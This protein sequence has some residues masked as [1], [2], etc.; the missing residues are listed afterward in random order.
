MSFSLT[1]FGLKEMLRCGL[2]LRKS[3]G[4]AGTLEEVARTVVRYFHDECR[5]AEGSRECLLARFYKTH[6]YGGLPPDLQAFA[7]GVLAPDPPSNDMQCLTLLATAGAEP[8]WNAR[9]SSRGHQAIPL[10]SVQV[11][12]QAPM[13]AELVRAMGLDVRM[14]VDPDAT[15]IRGAEGKT[16]NVFYVPQAQGSPHIPAQDFVQRYSVC[17]VLGFGG[18]LVTGEFYA[19]ILFTR[20]TIPPESADRFR[21]VAL[22]LKLA[23]S[24]AAV[25]ATFGTVPGILKGVKPLEPLEPRE[26]TGAAGG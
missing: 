25:N 2:D 26:P 7:R 21:N 14:V 1:Q 23:I 19:V 6:A 5:D 12:E 18:V 17:S 22:D 16:F 3:A 4:E 13:I 24:S 10:A 15:L 20:V 9:E 11:V 8:E